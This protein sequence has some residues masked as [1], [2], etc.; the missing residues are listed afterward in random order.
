MHTQR[1]SRAELIAELENTAAGCLAGD[2]LAE[3]AR[4]AAQALRDGAGEVRAGHTT[5]RVDAAPD[6]A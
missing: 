5:Y 4:A 1:G 6:G 3:E 2:R